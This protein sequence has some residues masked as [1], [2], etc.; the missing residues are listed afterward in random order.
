MPAE[1]NNELAVW[2]EPDSC[3]AANSDAWSYGKTRHD[4]GNRMNGGAWNLSER[5]TFLSANEQRRARRS[6]RRGRWRWA[7]L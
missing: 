3:S 4:S 2:P 5:R 7:A 1:P 6:K